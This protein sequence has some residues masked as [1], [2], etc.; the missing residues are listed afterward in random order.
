MSCPFEASSAVSAAGIHAAFCWDHDRCDNIEDQ[1]A[2]EGAEQAEG[3]PA[4]TDQGGI[5][6][7]LLRDPAAHTADHLKLALRSVQSLFVHS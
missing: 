2:K 5:D 6:V 1:A 4:Q 3:R 7:K